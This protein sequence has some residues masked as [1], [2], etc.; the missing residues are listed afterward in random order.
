MKEITI[1]T[2]S[3]T[4]NVSCMEC[5][6]SIRK[7]HAVLVLIFLYICPWCHTS[8]INYDMMFFISFIYLTCPL[9]LSP[10]MSLSASYLICYNH[11]LEFVLVFMTT[12][13][14]H[15]ITKGSH[16]FYFLNLVYQGYGHQ[17]N[18]KTQIY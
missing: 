8:D 1:K 13:T 9:F 11:F 2:S 5:Q 12:I 10:F 14:A 15:V 16:L 7:I 4:L 18:Y 17:G 6:F 3:I